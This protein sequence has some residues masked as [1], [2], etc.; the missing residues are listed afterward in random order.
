M[1][2]E[3]ESAIVLTWLV[4]NDWKWPIASPLM[5]AFDRKWR[6]VLTRGKL[7]LQYYRGVKITQIAF[8]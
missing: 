6:L 3:S 4:P 2:I 8:T 5:Q 1:E 7:W